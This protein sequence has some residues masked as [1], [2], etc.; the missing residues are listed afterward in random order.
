MSYYRLYFMS[1]FSGHIEG[2]EEFD[3]EDDAQAVKL[4]ETRQGALGMELWCLHR[5]VRQFAALDLASQLLEQRHKL[6]EVKHQLE[7]ELPDD[8]SRPE[9]RKA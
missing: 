9:N 8:V 5:R 2:F 4:A 6:K 7:T 3:A 1:S